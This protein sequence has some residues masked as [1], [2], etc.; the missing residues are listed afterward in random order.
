MPS[1]PSEASRRGVASVAR[2]AKTAK[3][4]KTS[5]TASVAV[6]VGTWLNVS[7]DLANFRTNL[8]HPLKADLHLQLT[9]RPEV[10][11]CNSSITCRVEER[12]SHLGTIAGLYVEQ[13]VTEMQL[14]AM[15]K[16]SLH[17]P[18]L[19][20]WYA[21]AGGCK[22]VK[23]PKPH[24]RC[25]KIP[26]NGNSFMAPIFG[27]PKLNVLRQI[28]L[29]SLVFQRLKEYEAH[30][31]VQYKMIVWSR[32]EL[33]WLAPH[34]PLY[35]L[36]FASCPVWTQIG[37]DYAGL[38]DR[39]AILTREIAPIYIGRWD[40]IFDG[41]L[42]DIYQHSI[43][44]HTC[45]HQSS[46]RYLATTL[47]H[48]NVSHCYF[49]PFAFLMCC[50]KAGNCYKN[51]CVNMQV[52]PALG[53]TNET[54]KNETMD[55][56]PTPLS[57]SGKYSKEVASALLHAAALQHPDA[58]LRLAPRNF[59]YAGS[60]HSKILQGPSHVEVSLPAH[61]FRALQRSS[62]V[63]RVRRILGPISFNYTLL[64]RIS[65]KSGQAP[66]AVAHKHAEYNPHFR[67]RA[68]TQN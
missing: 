22:K 65:P 44:T 32:L 10:D 19:Q 46:E 26:E 42:F 41:R 13:Q 31:G 48:Y 1:H 68:F 35:T 29:Q 62:D 8:L 3:T 34:P 58:Q 27:N 60:D 18:K 36:S 43:S 45:P 33:Q 6:L 50:A 15:L 61:V 2:T 24:Y 63:K 53:L 30:R 54:E 20:A 59:Q 66:P 25:P 12:F 4:A 40:A 64:A 14:L 51:T 5:R 9:Y 38:N 37:E 67:K 23:G 17:W 7:L 21:D 52:A 28:Y 39:H 49:P 47:A 55:S 16:A 11:N 56:A 57:A